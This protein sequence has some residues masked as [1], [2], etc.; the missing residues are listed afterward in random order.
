MPAPI[1]NQ[2]TK[3]TQPCVEKEWEMVKARD[4]IFDVQR[5]IYEHPDAPTEILDDAK[6][7]LD[8]L[9]RA[10]MAAMEGNPS[11]YDCCRRL[12]ALVNVGLIT[13]EELVAR[14]LTT[15]E[16][17]IKTLN[18]DEFFRSNPIAW[19]S[20]KFEP[21]MEDGDDVTDVCLLGMPS[22]G[23][24]CVLMG[25][26]GSDKY[27][28]N[29][30]IADGKYGDI[31]STYRDNHLLS[32]HTLDNL[33]A[34]IHGTVADSK[35]GKHRVNLIELAGVRFLDK[36]A[37]NPHKEITLEDMVGNVAAKLLRNDNRK[38]FFIVIDPTNLEIRWGKPVRHIDEEGCEYYDYVS[39]C[40]SQKLIIRG[41]A[42]ALFDPS[43]AEIIKRVDALH[44]IVTKWD[45]M[46]ANVSPR[47]CINDYSLSVNVIEELCRSK[48][49]HINEA[50]GFKPKLYTFSLGKFYVGGTFDFDPTD[51]DKLMDVITDAVS[52]AA[53]RRRRWYRRLLRTIF[54]TKH[55]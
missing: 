35:G 46:G 16:A 33:F 18:R 21:N 25:L 4:D 24:T 19:S 43:N 13:V 55:R 22:A 9:K 12:L 41:I 29:N 3:D 26:L 38:I 42:N 8:R 32:G 27:I 50:T 39:C 52:V 37:E 28:W 48:N 31:L 17:F 44:F 34:S 15:R 10:E 51:S 20:N 14:G 7:C 49:A 6:S 23:K 1:I 40:L 54:G 47:D 5:Y 11:G 45:A 2:K 53:K 30:A 36:L